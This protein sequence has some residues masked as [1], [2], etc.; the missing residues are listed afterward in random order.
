M[1]RETSGNMRSIPRLAA[2]VLLGCAAAWSAAAP[3]GASVSPL[4]LSSSDGAGTI[5]FTARPSMTNRSSFVVAN[6]GPT[7]RTVRLV[8]VPLGSGSAGG[9]AFGERALRGP[10]TWIEL[11]R[12]IV[13]VP[14][15]RMVSVAFSAR[16]PRRPGR[17]DRY[18]GI[19]AVDDALA[20]AAARRGRSGVASLVRHALSVRFRLPG[21]RTS[22]LIVTG[23]KSR[24]TAGGGS[25]R[26]GMANRG[27]ALIGSTRVH[28]E[29]RRGKELVR[30]VRTAFGQIVP[31][32]EFSYALRLAGVAE[33]TYRVTGTLRPDRGPAVRVDRRVTFSPGDVREMR[34][35]A[36]AEGKAVPERR[37]PV[38][39]I[40]AAL[41]ALLLVALLLA[42][43]R[44][45][46]NRRQ[47][48]LEAKLAGLEA[49]LERVA[50]ERTAA[51]QHTDV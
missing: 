4:S 23:A 24:R 51:P 47:R 11:E 22:R 2:T 8:A 6:N 32:A 45:A 44:R 43:A 7:A 40:V 29:I 5:R 42:V 1:S 16:V 36:E 17:G 30:S 27:S 35:Q 41:A 25:I 34:R 20:T 13:R 9:A 14:A 31:D 28:L 38:V 19:V 26:L 3:A 33:G 39:V 15:H 18:A 49:A 46:R 48:D 12:R 21:P 37:L 50:A 10:A